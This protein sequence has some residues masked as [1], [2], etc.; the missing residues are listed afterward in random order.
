MRLCV[1]GIYN[2]REGGREEQRGATEMVV[3]EVK[4]AVMVAA[5]VR[6]VR[7][8]HRTLEV[9]RKHKW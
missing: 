1:G 3:T 8:R 6:R 4:T 5:V 2:Y 7:P 9:L